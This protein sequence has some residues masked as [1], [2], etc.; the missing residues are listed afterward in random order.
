MDGKIKYTGF[1]DFAL[2]PK[3]EAKAVYVPPALPE[4]PS[5]PHLYYYSGKEILHT[6]KGIYAIYIN[7]AYISRF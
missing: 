7:P 2:I 6:K 4:I 5:R 3:T 1:K